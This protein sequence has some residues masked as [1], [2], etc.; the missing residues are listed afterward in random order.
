MKVVKQKITAYCEVT[1]LHGWQYLASSETK[2]V[3]KL[4]WSV[5]IFLSYCLATHFILANCKEYLDAKT[6]TTI[7]STTSSLEHVKFPSLIICNLN[8]VTKSFMKRIGLDE[9][10]EDELIKEFIEGSDSDDL[11]DDP[12]RKNLI[13]NTLK[14]IEE[15]FEYHDNRTH[16]HKISSQNC[17]EM[18]MKVKWSKKPEKYF[19]QAYID[20]TE[21]GICCFLTPYLDFGSD[22]VNPE[23]YQGKD[24]NN[25]PRGYAKNGLQNGLMVTVDLESFDH[26]IIWDSMGFK[27]GLVDPQDKILLRNDGFNIRPGVLTEVAIMPTITNTSLDAIEKFDPLERDC[28]TEDEYKLKYFTLEHGFRYSMR[29]CLYNVLLQKIVDECQCLTYLDFDKVKKFNPTLSLCQGSH[30]VPCANSIL[31][32]GENE[33]LTMNRETQ[34][35]KKCLQ[36][37]ES[38]ED[39]FILSHLTYPHPVN[40]YKHEDACLIMEKLNRICIDSYKQVVFDAHYKNE[41]SCSQ[42]LTFYENFNINCTTDKHLDLAKL[43]ENDKKVMAFLYKYATEN[44]AKIAVYLK[45]SFYTSIK[46]DVKISFVDFISN[47]GGLMG[48]CLGFSLISMFEFIYHCLKCIFQL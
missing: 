3:F 13:E 43:D 48:L 41:I 24:W 26:A 9:N 10:D 40:F 46:K 45:N 28:Y 23:E 15:K 17:S 5:I 35:F 6:I 44:V 42:I 4:F 20:S 18:L 37:C 2:V 38:Q 12:A 11:N 7:E 8:Q 1:T 36:R 27:V 22:D 16:I 33:N 21:Y 29:N 30:Q 39:N 47:T 32:N 14:T 31:L 34:D 25:I 19:F